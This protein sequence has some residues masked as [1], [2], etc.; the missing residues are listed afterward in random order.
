MTPANDVD[1]AP[2]DGEHVVRGIWGLVPSNA[3]GEAGE[4][5]RFS[6]VHAENLETFVPTGTNS[7]LVGTNDGF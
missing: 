3:P 5:V 6:R 1:T 7:V 4:Y 2:G